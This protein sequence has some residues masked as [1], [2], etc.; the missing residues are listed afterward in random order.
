MADKMTLPAK[1]AARAEKRRTLTVR[2]E[3]T[4]YDLASVLVTASEG[5]SNYWAEI[6]VVD[7]TTFPGDSI[8]LQTRIHVRD[9]ESGRQWHVGLDAMARGLEKALALCLAGEL[10]YLRSQLGCIAGIDAPAADL[11]LQLATL[12]EI[13]YG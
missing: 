13:V 4:D 2:C 6:E 10:G 3:V 11:V 1:Y 7:R 12:G 9:R 8:P 5:G